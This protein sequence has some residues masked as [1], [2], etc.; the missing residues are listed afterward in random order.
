M[1]GSEAIPGPTAM[2]E[3]STAAAM[4]SFA[5]CLFSAVL[6]SSTLDDPSNSDS[7][8]FL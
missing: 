8:I 2:L 3:R 7:S 6:I 5:F 4:S 1:P